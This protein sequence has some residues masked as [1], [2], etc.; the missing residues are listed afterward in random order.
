[1]NEFIQT[2]VNYNQYEQF[3]N[4]W[5]WL[6]LVALVWSVIW[7][8]L[9][10]WHSARNMQ[11]VWFVVLLVVNTVGILEIIY[12]LGFKKSRMN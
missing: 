4:Q 8:G 11:K 10:L 5:G 1:M 3:F 2:V 7:K 12:L 6:M 9:A